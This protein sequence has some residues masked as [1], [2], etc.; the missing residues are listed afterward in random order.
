MSALLCLCCLL[1][2]PAEPPAPGWQSVT[3][4]LRRPLAGSD[5]AVLLRR[6]PAWQQSWRPD[7]RALPL[8]PPTA[9]GD[10]LTQ[11]AS[12]DRVAAAVG[13]TRL[14][15]VTPTVGEAGWETSQNPVWL[16][17]GGHP[18]VVATPLAHWAAQLGTAAAEH[19]ALTCEGWHRPPT[20]AQFGAQIDALATVA[21]AKDKHLELWLPATALLPDRAS[22]AWLAALTAE[23]LARLQR[24]LLYDSHAARRPGGPDEVVRPSALAPAGDYTR[25]ATAAA[26]WAA[27]G[28]DLL[29]SPA[30]PLRTVAQGQAQLA[31]LAAAG[32]GHLLL[33]GR[34][35]TPQA[36]VWNAL[37]QGLPRAQEPAATARTGAE[38]T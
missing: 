19:L 12:L 23:R 31:D 33:R 17:L 14:V 6:W 3:F 27:S 18:V 15:V 37:L 22:P 20:A 32:F 24:V 4:A 21:A 8:A 38:G 16:P 30:V 11:L 10:L 26:T 35:D 36:P 29:D 5:E 1:A 25:L 28:A 9:G 13:P 7:R 34:L 2:T